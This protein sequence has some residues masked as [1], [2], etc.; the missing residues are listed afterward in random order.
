MSRIKILLLAEPS[1]G[2]AL[3]ESVTIGP[4]QRPPEPN[5]SKLSPYTTYSYWYRVKKT[6][7]GV[8]SLTARAGGI[9]GHSIEIKVGLPGP[10]IP[11]RHDEDFS[12]Q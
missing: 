11:S 1:P 6:P 9:H 10:F 7:E 8:S 2:K 5:K 4:I 3:L 12:Q